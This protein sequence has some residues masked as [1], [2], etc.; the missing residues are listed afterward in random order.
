MKRSDWDGILVS[1]PYNLRAITGFTGGTGYA[2]LAQGKKVLMTDS[3]YLEQAEKE[4][5]EFEVILVSQDRTYTNVLQELVSSDIK[6]LGFEDE[7]MTYASVK[8][9]QKALPN[10]EWI[11]LGN[12]LVLERMVKQDW[13]LEAMRRAEHIGDLAFSHILPLIK[14][15][16]T[17][18]EV[19]A[20]L[21]YFM[22][23]QGA[24]KTSF[25]TIVASG[26]HSSMPHAVPDNKK[27][28]PGD[29]ITMDFGCVYQGYCSDMTRTVVLGKADSQQKKVYET[30]L[31][32]QEAA[33]SK[34]QA[35]MCCKD[36]DQ[37][38]RSIIT[39]AGY[40]AYFGHALGHGVGLEIH[41]EP[42]LSKA[43]DTILQVNMIQ[44]VEPGI[45]IPGFGGVR[46]E[47]MVIIKENGCENLAESPKEL[48][49]L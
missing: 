15:G 49:E 47:D 9:L 17:E 22:K 27:I 41:E 26:L 37:I 32:A 10:L 30:V 4:A 7:D 20:E 14:P 5:K 16:I 48:L 33:L 21:E 25:D 38:A 43:C 29:F 46:I 42:R 2:F 44:T 13:E 39:E 36:V 28:E 19:A 11:P 31:R 3:R 18:L 1:N 24:E 12:T 8:K 34:I 6:T 23:K 40:G 45:Y 35:G